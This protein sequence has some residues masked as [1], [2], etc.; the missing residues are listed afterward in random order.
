MLIRTLA[1]F[2]SQRAKPSPEEIEAQR[3]AK[4]VCIYAQNTHCALN[5][6]RLLHTHSLNRLLCQTFVYHQAVK[7]ARKEA[8][9]AR[10]V[11]NGAQQPSS[12]SGSNK[13]DKANPAANGIG[14]PPGPSAAQP[15]STASRSSRP[16][17][18]ST[19]SLPSSPSVLSPANPLSASSSAASASASSSALPPSGTSLPRRDGSQ[20]QPSSRPQLQYDN[21][22]KKKKYDKNAVLLRTQVA[23]AHPLFSHLPQYERETS[24]SLKVRELS[25]DIPPAVLRL[26]LAYSNGDV[27]GSNAR[28]VAM[29]S[30]FHSVI[31]SYE[32]TDNKILRD[33]L[34]Q[35]LKPWVRFIT[36]CRPMSASMGNALRTLKLKISKIHPHTA[37]AEAKQYLLDEIDSY[38]RERITLAHQ[39]IVQAAVERI[40]DGDVVMTYATSY[41]IQQVLLTAKQ[42]GKDFTVVVVDSRPKHEGRRLLQALSGAGVTC[43]YCLVSSLSSIIQSV[44]LV[45]LSAHSMLSNGALISRCGTAIVAMVAHRRRIPVL[46]CCETYKFVSRVQLDAI[47]SNELADPDELLLA[48]TAARPTGE[49]AG[50]GDG[51]AAGGSGGGSGGVLGGW[52]DV[53]G[54]KLL[55]LVY[56]LT[57]VEFV[58]MVVTEVGNVPPTSVPVIV[59]EYD[60]DGDAGDF[61]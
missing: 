32:V 55:N 50:S 58:T 27:T 10:L 28:C 57:P 9:T 13:K 51:A 36:D 56:D 52:R 43:H 5:T 23:K 48:N 16:L 59:R 39:V 24:L 61:D 6:P 30:A 40:A 1:L 35:R 17:Q 53:A 22:K 44:T 34:L 18:L 25:G 42:Q 12:K 7:A 37:T 38:I 15:P 2:V 41:V 14:S 20:S 47:C 26:G 60:K 49:Q 33:D 3:K 4:Q 31:R 19:A 46:V 8:G 54:L 11:D 21:A 45:L 29:L